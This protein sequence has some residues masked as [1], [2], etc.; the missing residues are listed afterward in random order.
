MAYVVTCPCGVTIRDNNV[1][2]FVEVVQKHAKGVH[3]QDLSR[4]EILAMGRKE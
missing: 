4:E 1:E 3:N 2:Q